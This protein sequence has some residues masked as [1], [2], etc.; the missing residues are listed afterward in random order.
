MWLPPPDAHSTAV[1]NATPAPLHPLRGPIKQLTR[2][3]RERAQSSPRRQAPEQGPP[4]P[5]RTEFIGW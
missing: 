2:S 4:H 5:G 3:V 1:A